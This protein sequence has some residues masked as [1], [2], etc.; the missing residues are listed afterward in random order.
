MLN[1][2]T[3]LYLLQVIEAINKIELSTDGL[4]LDTYENYEVKWIV[5]R[6]L[7]IIGE[8]LNRIRINEPRLVI[9]NQQKIVSTRNKIAHEYDVV[10]HSILYTIVTKYLPLLK[11]EV[12]TI[13]EQNRS[14][15]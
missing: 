5:E 1:E 7:E 4:S 15:N 12:E 9:P 14:T 11:S 13:L 6:G 8:A 2:K 10:D 3:R